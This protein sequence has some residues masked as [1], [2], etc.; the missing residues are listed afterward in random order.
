[1]GSKRN[2]ELLRRGSAVAAL[3]GLG[4]FLAG[5][6]STSLSSMTGGLVGS[7]SSADAGAP[8]AGAP[9]PRDTD[10]PC[11]DTDVLTG[12]STLI[13]GRGADGGA[14]TPLDV[15]YQ[16]SITRIDRECH[17]F[18]GSMHIKVGVEGRVI[19]GPAGAPGTVNV[20]LR[21]AVVQ[22]GVNPVTIATQLDEVPVTITSA[23]G[24]VPFAHIYPD[25]SF[26]LPHPVGKIDDY[27]IYVGFDAIGA[28]QKKRPVHHRRRAPRRR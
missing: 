25:V 14:P 10:L 11:P 19:T 13:V 23:V 28:Q 27:K 22:A 8:A 12:A 6:S 20:P 7:S 15:R 3:V 9:P 5:C 26:V 21:V 1:M 18:A 17:V 24:N 4:L 16:G 2:A